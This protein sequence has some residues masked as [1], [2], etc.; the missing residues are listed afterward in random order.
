MIPNE[1]NDMRLSH[2]SYSHAIENTRAQADTEWIAGAL[3]GY[4]TALLLCSKLRI[5]PSTLLETCSFRLTSDSSLLSDIA[6]QGMVS[7]QSQ[8]TPAVVALMAVAPNEIMNSVR[9][10]YAEAIGWYSKRKEATLVLHLEAIL[11]FASFYQQL[12]KRRPSAAYPFPYLTLSNTAAT[13]GSTFVAEGHV[14]ALYSAMESCNILLHDSAELAA[15]LPLPTRV[16]CYSDC[17]THV[18]SSLTHWLVDRM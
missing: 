16:R 5:N 9:E 3:E 7:T 12:N 4:C 15:S 11:K 14:A 8:A 17:S 1:L 6:C 2:C 18:Y 10:K 13:L